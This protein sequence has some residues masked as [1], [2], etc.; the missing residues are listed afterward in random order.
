MKHFKKW[1]ITALLTMIAIFAMMITSQAA[2]TV[3]VTA[4][5]LNIRRGPSTDADI[6]AMLSEGVECEVLGEEGDWYQIQYQRY[7]GYVSKE[8]VEVVGETSSSEEGNSQSNQTTNEQENN[9]QSANTTGEGTQNTTNENAQNTNTANENAQSN[10]ESNETVQGE[11][12]TTTSQTP[13]IVYKNLKQNTSARILPLIYAS[14]IGQ[15]NT[16]TEVLL[17]T[18]M[19]GWSYIQAEEFNGWVRSDVLEDSPNTATGNNG[20][21]DDTTQR[22][23]YVSEQSVN[24]REGAG[25]NHSVIR[26]LSLNSQVTILGEEGDWYQVQSGDDT[27]YIS[28]EYVSDTRN[29]TSRANTTPRGTQDE[30]DAEETSTNTQKVEEQNSENQDAEEQSQNDTSNS[31]DTTQ[32]TN[33]GQNENATTSSKTK[34][35]DVVAYAKKYL[36]YPYVYGGNGSNGTFDCS[37]FTMYVYEHFG[38]SLPHGATSQYRSGKGTKVSKQSELKTGD[39][40]FL[41]DYETGEGIG[42][43]GI[44]IGDG[45]FIHASTTTYTVTISSL[46]TMYAGRFYA[47]L[48][49]I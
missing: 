14:T 12:N 29:T 3:R 27:G 46:N 30:E 47:G 22:I 15:L 20:S 44:Y 28:K 17:I 7:T 11:E 45:N 36:G 16:G 43:C 38:I 34:G 9:N 21:S 35:T 18:E 31:N 33:N 24:L 19:N 42:H 39:I 23:G 4:E 41:T 26:V 10:T 8:Y 13:V 32:T 6:I 2:T 40:V 37:G 5:T 49:L 1:L 25:T 48:R